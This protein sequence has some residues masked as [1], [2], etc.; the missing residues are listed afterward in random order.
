MIMVEGTGFGEDMSVV[1]AWIGTEPANVVG[2]LPEMIQ[3]EVPV[4]VHRGAVKIKIGDKL[5]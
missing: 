2:V 5:S 3:I 1:K 4:G